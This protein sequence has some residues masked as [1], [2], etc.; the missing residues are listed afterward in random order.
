MN[1]IRRLVWLTTFFTRLAL[2][3]LYFNYK[4]DAAFARKARILFTITC[5]LAGSSMTYLTITLLRHWS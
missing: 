1:R 2:I 4:T 3:G 5:C